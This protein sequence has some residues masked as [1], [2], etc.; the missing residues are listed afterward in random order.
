VF[1]PSVQH[2]QYLTQRMVLDKIPQVEKISISMPNVHYFGF[3]FT[4]FP[5]IPG[6]ASSKAGEVYHPVDK[7]SGQIRS[8]LARAD[9]K[10]RL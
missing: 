6:L 10:A 3:D 1:S 4:R 9:I 5:R 7:P 2:S 8:T